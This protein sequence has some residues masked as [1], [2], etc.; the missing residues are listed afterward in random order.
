[1]STSHYASRPAQNDVGA[2]TIRIT[3]P[4]VAHN[5]R[6]RTLATQVAWLAVGLALLLADGT[7]MYHYADSALESVCIAL[8][9]M[10][11]GILVILAALQIRK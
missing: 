11:T 10:P 5:R 7:A 6:R 8:L 2:D 3:L 9:T 4:Q 1:M